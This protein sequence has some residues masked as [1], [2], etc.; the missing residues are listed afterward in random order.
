MTEISRIEIFCE[1]RQV[2]RIQRM[3]VGLVIKLA[4]QPVVNASVTKNGLQAKTGGSALEMLAHHLRTTK[5]KVITAKELQAFMQQIGRSPWSYTILRDQAV[6]T[7]LLVKL[8]KGKST[9]YRVQLKPRNGGA[10]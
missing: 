9:K 10:R 8:G 6:T 5:K 1:D 7:K 4:S 2:G 3:L